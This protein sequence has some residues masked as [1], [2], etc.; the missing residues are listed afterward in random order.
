MP[1]MLHRAVQPIGPGQR[2]FLATPSYG[3]LSPGYT[4]ALFH[5][6]E[7][8]RAAGIAAEL[9]IL[10]GDCH[11][12]D[13]RNRLV[14]DFLESA[15]TDL[16]FLDSD[17][18]WLPEDLVALCRYDRDV[19]AASYPLKQEDERFPVLPLDNVSPDA[20]GLIEVEGVPTGFLR[21]RRGVIE[22]LTAE[23]KHFRSKG[24]GRSRAPIPL[25][26]E[27]SLRDGVRVSGDYTFCL[28]WRAAGGK[29]FLAPEMTIEHTGSEHWKGSFAAWLRRVAG[30][31]LKHCLDAI[32]MH[33]ET[34]DTFAEANRAW[35]N[36]GFV[37][38]TEMLAAL[39]MLAREANG[40]ILE[41]G[42]G[43]ST[44]C[45]A[46]ANPR[47]FVLALEQDRAWAERVADQA[48]L[49]GLNNVFVTHVPLNG[50]G[51]YDAPEIA[52]HY[53]IVLLDGPSRGAGNRSGILDAKV[54]ADVWVVDDVDDGQ[55]GRIIA[56]LVSRGHV[57]KTMGTSRPFAVA[58]RR[59]IAEAAE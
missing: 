20:D 39:T 40:G 52:G 53:G 21:I 31:S 6:A 37:S 29:V 30:T 13:S 43:L 48:R 38:T 35:G 32:A 8:L 18:R 19:V 57:A 10:A 41:C 12:D 50:A 14:R 5:S 9:A 17:I 4:Y 34:P 22:R 25:I 16:V 45:M 28:K 33:D 2:V 44:L 59:Q 7:V 49:H 15:C 42:S 11:V 24:D 47:T 54:T 23:A 36:T 56:D 55:V 27:R 3:D 26:F 46:A 1:R 58:G 51:W